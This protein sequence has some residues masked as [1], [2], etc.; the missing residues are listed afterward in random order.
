MKSSSSNSNNNNNNTRKLKVIC[1]GAVE[2]NF[3]ILSEKLNSLNK[4]KAGPFDVCICAGPFFGVDVPNS[5]DQAEALLGLGGGECISL[6]FPLYF[7]DLGI[8]PDGI[9]ISYLQRRIDADADAGTN[10]SNHYES[11][12][13]VACSPSSDDGDDDASS[14]VVKNLFRLTTLRINSDGD[15]GKQQR[16]LIGEDM[17]DICALPEGNLVVAYVPLHTRVYRGDL[18]DNSCHP[19]QMKSS[20]NAYMGCDVLVSSEWGQ[21]ITKVFTDIDQKK[22]KAMTANLSYPINELGSY[23]VAEFSALCKPRYHVAPSMKEADFLHFAALPYRNVVSVIND[24]TSD[25]CHITRF[26]S[27]GKVKSGK[28]LPK[29]HKFLHAVNILTLTA[30][31][32]QTLT[33]GAANAQGCPYTDMS[34]STY[35]KGGESSV[36]EQNGSKR[37]GLS[38]AAARSI[39]QES[40]VS[41]ANATDFRW[42]NKKR[43]RSLEESPN[44]NNTTLHVSGLFQPGGPEVL[45]VDILEQLSS[46]GCS[47]VRI[48]PKA[49]GR[50]HSNY[51]FLDFSSHED[52]RKCLEKFTD[53]SGRCAQIQV[54]GLLL[55]LNWSTGSGARCDDG[56]SVAQSQKRKRLTESEAIDSNS[57]HFKPPRFNDNNNGSEGFDSLLEAIRSAAERT[58][59]DAIQPNDAAEGSA[60]ITA[61]DEPALAV[62][63]KK[64]TKDE[65]DVTS[66]AFLDF[67]SHAAASMALQLLTGSLDG[68]S[69]DANLPIFDDQSKHLLKG[70]FLNWS[71][72]QNRTPKFNPETRTD[73]W[74][75]LASP[76]C[77]KHLIVAIN[78]SCYLT[79]PKGP[80]N[81]HHILVVPLQHDSRNNIVG[82]LC[83]ESASEVQKVIDRYRKFTKDV[84]Q[85]ELFVFERAFQTKGG[86]HSHVQ[87]IPVNTNAAKDLHPTVTTMLSRYNI[88]LKEVSSDLGLKAVIQNQGDDDET[89]LN[90]GYFYVELPL[91]DGGKKRLVYIR[92]GSEESKGFVP[93]QLGREVAAT[94]MKMDLEKAHWKACVLDEGKETELASTLRTSIE[95]FA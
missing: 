48:V 76:T 11:I 27:L 28:K 15:N 33:D 84:L 91:P 61:Q 32:Q 52:A 3:K 7:V 42:S 83:G 81:E 89:N 85:K 62:K 74:F 18:K 66:Y 43:R 1:C 36:S 29:D 41:S 79:M 31:D 24:Q 47:K 5:E 35:Q 75:C 53:S 57:L 17:A 72:T 22:C 86:Y 56:R 49:G 19:L 59:E 12:L 20:H 13:A 87:C 80:L 23:D 21:G 92:D 82:A 9:H 39:M 71:A 68:G 51:G 14:S 55:D 37:G 34:Y 95:E 58:L 94:C 69:V 78:D 8:V 50:G 60:R 45:G 54:K 30:L 77:E 90:R 73:C 25:M 6:P 88:E 38:E 10:S 65:Q 44:E 2:G 63:Y 93:L 46:F 16:Q 67:A 70:S 4:S 40:N 64:I 26:I